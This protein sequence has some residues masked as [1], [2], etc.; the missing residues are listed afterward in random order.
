VG[1]RSRRPRQARRAAVALAADERN[2]CRMQLFPILN[3]A[4]RAFR[5]R[6]SAYQR[7]SR[8]RQV[9]FKQLRLPNPADRKIERGFLH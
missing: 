4:A 3:T 8:Y 6:D 5:S 7:E 1:R 2:L 9:L